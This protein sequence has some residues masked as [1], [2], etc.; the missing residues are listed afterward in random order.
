MIWLR[1]FNYLW[2]FEKKVCSLGLEIGVSHEHLYSRL[3]LET[4]WTRIRVISS[5]K[6]GHG[7]DLRHAGLVG[8]REKVFSLNLLRIYLTYEFLSVVVRN[9]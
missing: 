3:G 7:L 5:K 1:C 6:L 8:T 2:Y 4:C 9:P